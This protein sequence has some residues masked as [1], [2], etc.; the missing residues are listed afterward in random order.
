MMFSVL[1]PAYNCADV[2]ADTVDSI[3]RSGLEDYEVV[4][5][6]DGSTDQTG[7]VLEE[8]EARNPAVVVLSQPNG[9]VSA[10]RNAGLARAR[11]DYLVFVDADDIQEDG[12]FRNITE[13]ILR[14]RPDMLMFGMTFDHYHNGICYQCDRM[15][16]QAEGLYQFDELKPLLPALFD[17]NYLSPIWNK[18]IRREIVTEHGISFPESMFLM[19]DALFSLSC[20]S[21]CGTVYLC[22]DAVYHY[23]LTDDGARVRQR[24]NRI[25]SLRQYLAPYFELPDSFTDV[26]RSVYNMLLGQRV[27]AARTVGELKRAARD[28]KESPYYPGYPS[29]LQD[30]YEGRFCRIILRNRIT[31]TRHKLAVSCKAFKARLRGGATSAKKFSNRKHTI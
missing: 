16:W 2:I 7:A 10:A 6:N 25:G 23:A 17:R 5:V 24:L 22:S 8:L 19:E 13:I 14:E 21:R 12:A 29:S 27:Y 26:V 28:L 15:V 11:G 4:I 18:V 3:R 20:L 30:L 9:G 31:Q 1:I